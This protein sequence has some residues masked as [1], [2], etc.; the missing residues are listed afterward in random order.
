MLRRVIWIVLALSILGVFPAAA[1]QVKPVDAASFIPADFAGFIRVHLGDNSD[2]AL[3][4]LNIAAFTASLLAPG[5][6]TMGSNLFTYDDL[7]PVSKIFDADSVTFTSTILPWLDGEL[8]LAYRHF[9]GAL[10][11]DAKDTLMILPPKNIMQASSALS[12]VIKA[13]DLPKTE[14]YRD[15]NLYIGDTSAF[16]VTSQAVF[17]GAIETVKAALDV[18]AGAANRLI[19]SPIY[20][21]INGAMPE[22]PLIS[23]Y[24]TGESILPALNGLLNGQTDSQPILAAFGQALG[25]MRSDSSFE[26]RL[27][28]GGFDGAAASIQLEDD[29]ATLVASTLLHSRQTPDTSATFDESLLNFIP[30]STMFLSSGSN[31]SGMIEDVITALPLSNFAPQIF[32]GWPIQ[33]LGTDNPLTPAPSALDIQSAASAY[34]A[35]LSQFNHF[36]LQTDLLDYLSGNYVVALI[37]RPNNPLPVLD[38]PMD[39][40]IVAQSDQAETA[41]KGV[42]TL[43]QTVFGL[44]SQTVDP[45]EGWN[46]SG[47]GDGKTLVFRIGVQGKTLLITTGDA[48]Q[49]A[50]RAQNGDNRLIEQ[51]VWQD[52]SKDGRPDLYMDLSGFYNTFFP[53]A[54]GASPGGGQRTRVAARVHNQDNGLVEVDMRVILPFG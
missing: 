34:L 2:T 42:G 1:Q 47:V 4:G 12:A 9:D 35:T 50:L 38:I 24:V 36:N 27:F 28:N 52:L 33:T 46:F 43:L 30:R 48:D 6:V 32:A 49:D 14:L 11:V 25:Q 37:P 10:Q 21:A 26:K 54:G 18:Q 17:V 5:R 15:V 29:G 53:S 40:L 20:G 41:Q 3:R 23:A 19:D 22:N 39:V 51:S 13:Q 7:I 31:A 16:A 45:V 8:V 44:K